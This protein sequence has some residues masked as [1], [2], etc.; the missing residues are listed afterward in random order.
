M[1][2]GIQLHAPAALPTGKTRY[3]FYRRLGGPQRRSGQ[4]RKISLPRGFD[5][6]TVQPVTSRYTD[7][8]IPAHKVKVT[9]QDIYTNLKESQFW[10][11][12]PFSFD[13]TLLAGLSLWIQACKWVRLE[14]NGT[15]RTGSQ[16]SFTLKNILCHVKH[17]EKECKIATTVV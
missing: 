8:A 10:S 9:S 2:V 16:P 6:R 5:P 15:W 1:A 14:S 3:Q 7:W 13:L 4:V 12:A 11:S 17:T